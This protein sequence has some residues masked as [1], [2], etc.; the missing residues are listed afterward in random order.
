M[1]IVVIIGIAV[2][3]GITLIVGVVITALIFIVYG[4][5][6]CLIDI[7]ITCIRIDIIVTIFCDLI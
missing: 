6:A 5:V 7:C 2:I 1:G 4:A 3:L